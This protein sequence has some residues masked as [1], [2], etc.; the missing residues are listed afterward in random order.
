MANKKSDDTQWKFNDLKIT[1]A[2]MG[3]WTKEINNSREFRK[4]HF[5]NDESNTGIAKDCLDYYLGKQEIQSAGLETPIVD[6][7]IAPIVNTFMAAILY[8]NPEIMV[9]LKRQSEIPYQKEIAKSVFSYFQTELKMGWQNQQALFDGYVTGLGVKTNGYDSEFDTIEEKEK[10]TKTVKKRRGLGRGKGWKTVE[11]EVEEEIIKRREWITKEFPSN[12]RHSPF[13]TLVDPRAKSALPFDGKWVCLEYEV[14]YNEVKG[15]PAFTNTEDLAPSGAVGTD[16]EKI[17]WDDYKRSMCH[18]YQ[19]QISRKDGLYVLTLAKDYDKPLRYIKYPFEVEGFLT[20]FLTLNPTADAFYAPSDLWDLIPLQDEVNYIQS[21]MLE[22]IYKFLPKIGIMKDMLPDEEEVKNAIAKGDIGTILTLQSATVG[23]GHPQQAIQVLNFQL[24][25]NDKMAVL[26]N[27]KNDMR[28]RSGVTE[29]ELTGRTDSKTATEASIGARGS[30][31]RITARREKLRQFLKEDLRK[32]A[33]IV[34]QAADFPLLIRITG[35]RE[36]DPLT[37]VPVTERWLQLNR[38]DEALKG[39][40]ELDIDILSGQQ[41]NVEL[42]RRQ[43]LE[44]ANFLFSPMVEQTLAREGMKIDKTL[45]IKEFLRT[46]DQFREASELVVPMSPQEQQQLAMQQM[47]QSGALQKMATAPQG[48]PQ[49]DDQ[50]MGQMVAAQ[51][52]R[53]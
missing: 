14:P 4:K 26:Q 37:G 30:F 8:Q 51:Q 43:I 40:F 42:K 28:L 9:N 27:L 45:L 11:E 31:T 46:M 25:L 50:T 36:V 53:I 24:D 49:A 21:R 1:E 29:A 3:Y 6:N 5:Y 23:T 41:P 15:N 47:M 48:P 7:Q 13:M 20:T 52:G 34:I 44:T 18:L 22:A 10:I 32:F 35:I 38:V 19:I 12:L 33:Q 17:Q 2:E 16:K 39:E